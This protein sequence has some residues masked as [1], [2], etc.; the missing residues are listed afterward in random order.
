MRVII[1]GCGRVGSLLAGLLSAD[2]HRVVVVDRDASAFGRLNKAGKCTTIEGNAFDQDILKRAGIE[3]ADA[4]ASV[5]A[6]DNS[7]YVLAAMARNRFKV[8]RVVTRIYDPTRA[9]I[10]RRLGVP[11]IS[12]TVWGANE[13]R[14]LL[15]SIG[16]TSVLSVANGEVQVVEAEIGPLL[17][18]T[19]VKDLEIVG[20]TQVVALV[21][22]GS[23]LIP[24]P[25]TALVRGDKVLVAVMASAMPGLERMLSP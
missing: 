25:E 6:G 5:T 21:R 17:A 8:P 4:F 16:L 15:T 24:S 23:G 13:I 11:I 19:Q 18:G 10:F 14:E 9:D 7:N 2:G 12:S 1:V 20:Q 22:G 3:S